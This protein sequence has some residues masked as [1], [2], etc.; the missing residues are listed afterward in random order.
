REQ[1]AH[2]VEV[3]KA[4]WTRRTKK[5]TWDVRAASEV[6]CYLA[7]AASTVLPPRNKPRKP[8]PQSI[9]QTNPVDYWARMLAEE[10]SPEDLR[11]HYVLHEMAKFDRAEANDLV[12]RLCSDAKFLSS[13][14]RLSSNRGTARTKT[15]VREVY[16]RVLQTEGATVSSGHPV[17]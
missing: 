16:D 11:D 14:E 12:G 10:V 3:L 13:W 5:A 1:S 4:D 15:L 9:Q 7:P 2:V 8:G 17:I 6:I